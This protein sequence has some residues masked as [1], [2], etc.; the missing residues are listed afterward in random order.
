MVMEN[1]MC[2]IASLRELRSA[3]RENELARN[4]AFQRVRSVSLKVV[5]V[6]EV[7]L[8]LVKRYAPASIKGIMQVIYKFSKQQGV[9]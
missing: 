6:S 5:S 2:R 3:L 4:A 8:L 7:L 1:E 9:S